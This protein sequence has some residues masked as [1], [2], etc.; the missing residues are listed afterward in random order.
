MEGNNV[1]VTV[2]D[3]QP[4]L[5]RF[6]FQALLT[7]PH[8]LCTPPPAAKVGKVRSLAA[9]PILDVSLEDVLARKHLPP[10][11]LKDFEEWLL[12]VEGCATELYFILW[13]REYTL[14]YERWIKRIR[15]RD[16]KGF[17]RRHSEKNGMYGYR[18]AWSNTPPTSPTLA[19]FF[20]RG[21]DTFF[22]SSS[23]HELPLPPELA[24][25]SQYLH[26]LGRSAHPDPLTLSAIRT[27]AEDS[28]RS[29]LDR[30]VR[31]TL[32][33]VGSYRA[34]CGIAGGSV[35]TLVGTV[36]VLAVNFAKGHS[37]WERL[38]ILPGL[39]LGLTV[40]FAS[41]CGICLMIYIFGDLRQLR[42]YVASFSCLT[43]SNL[44]SKL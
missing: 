13:L 10:L 33:N 6:S 7:L 30:C 16:S 11:S 5:T 8:R 1:A 31:A 22:C 25:H 39:W 38:A 28:L 29:S 41:L 19:L 23:P 26:A 15:E 18:A 21:L 35:I 12:F 17:L 37:R 20:A 32:S 4:R 24:S 9:T 43:G 42:R 40:L 27:Y 3:T 36:P 14:R 34:W 44:L 2:V